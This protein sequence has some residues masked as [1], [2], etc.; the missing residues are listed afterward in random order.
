MTSD[1]VTKLQRAAREPARVFA[2]SDF[3]D[4]REPMWRISDGT[5]NWYCAPFGAWAILGG[6][7][8]VLERAL[9][10]WGEKPIRDGGWLAD[11]LRAQSQ[12]VVVGDPELREVCLPK[13][14]L[15]PFCPVG[16]GGRRVPAT[17][18]YYAYRRYG[19]GGHWRLFDGRSTIAYL[20]DDKPV[21]VIQ[22]AR[23]DLG[24]LDAEAA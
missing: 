14:Q 10:K 11:L 21:V 4:L 5:D 9:Q 13:P 20:V 6:D 23:T 18:V 1:L 19:D 7:C 12:P 2:Q 24:A 3:R 15:A 17:P 8:P 22:L 16:E